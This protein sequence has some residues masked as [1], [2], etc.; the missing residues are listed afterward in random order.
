MRAVFS[1]AQALWDT[2]DRSEALDLF[3][4]L[5]HLNRG[6]NQGVRQYLTPALIQ[7]GGLEE[8]KE[9]LERQNESH[10]ASWCYNRALL[11]FLMED[12]SAL[13]KR[14]LTAAF[15]VNTHVPPFLTGEKPLP[16][17][18]PDYYRPGDITEAETIIPEIF[19]SWAVSDGARDWLGRRWK[20]FLSKNR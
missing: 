8:A 13:A 6:D 18:Q 14:R 3:R 5:M 15:K 16:T 17:S 19:A 2:G 20:F 7:I 9:L 4:E 1:L 10:S 11:T 12:D